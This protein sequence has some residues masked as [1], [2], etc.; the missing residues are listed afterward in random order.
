MASRTSKLEQITRDSGS[1]VLL[2]GSPNLYY[3]AEYEGA[4]AVLRCGENTY[5][6]TP[7][8]DA[9]RAQNVKGAEVVI[10][11][12]YNSGRFSTMI[13]ALEKLVNGKRLAVDLAWIQVPLYN[14]LQAKFELVD[15]SAQISK[16]R[17]IKESWELERISAAG[18]VTSS[19]MKRGAEALV[20]GVT[21]Y[22]VAGE[23]DATMRKS[24]AED[25][26]FPSIVAFGPDTAFPHSQP[27][28]RELRDEDN[29]LFDIGAKVGG[30]CFDS[31][32][33]F[34]VKGEVRKVYE[35]VLQAQGEAIDLVKPGVR[36]SDVD[37]AARKVIEKAGLGRYFIHATGHGVGIEV[38]ESPTVSPRSEDV[39]E[40]NM[41]ITVEPGVYFN[42]KFG[43]R[44]EDTII[45][46]YRPKV[47]STFP[48]ELP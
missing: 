26:A 11:D 34:Q 22:Q 1:C 8:L 21:E 30:Y 20:S 35:V 6:I 45:V 10:Y 12:P 16:L 33:T 25:Y 3:F 9:Y 27:R 18:E 46:D 37:L 38:H 43:V 41:V 2:L 5:V 29:A 17:A 19:A 47:L 31:T 48:K 28:G 23:I 42:G 36:A 14:V 24:G 4:G 40:R 15:I 7:L 39:L 13:S 32:R 44:I